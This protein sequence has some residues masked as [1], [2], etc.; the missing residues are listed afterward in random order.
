M[1]NTLAKIDSTMRALM[2]GA[3][4]NNQQLQPFAREILL[5]ECHVSGTFY[6]ELKNVEPSLVQ[7]AMLVLQREPANAHDNL[8]IRVCDSEGRQLGYIPRITNAPL[9]RLMDAGKQLFARL[10]AKSWHGDWLKINIGVY[11]RDF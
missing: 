6:K 9:A 10:E 1:N 11:M 2:H 8:A 4:Q 3:L 5:L 7:G